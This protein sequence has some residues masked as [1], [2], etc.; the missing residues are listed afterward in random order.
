[1]SLG[2]DIVPHKT[3]TLDCVYCESGKTTRLTVERKA[4]VP[5][6]RVKA[7]LTAFLASG[8]QLDFVTFSGAGEPTLHS[9]L[10]ELVGFIKATF[11]Q[12]K[13]ALLT[14][15]S[16]FYR[17]DVQDEVLDLDLVKVSLDAVCENNFRRIN[18][19]HRELEL[20]HIIEGLIAFR[21]K[22]TK[23]FWIEV[24]LVPGYNDGESELKEI[25]KVVNI[26]AGQSSTKHS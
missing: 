11:P 17:S 24:F 16:L 6:K 4:Y 10:G 5:L 9:G 7:E 12:Y 18:R 14:N 8:P 3:C 13:L 2:V 15:G 26:L 19:P 22:F 25:K 1:M 21:N 23:Q 20:S